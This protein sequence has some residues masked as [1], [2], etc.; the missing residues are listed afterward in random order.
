MKEKYNLFL[1]T[2]HMTA[3]LESVDWDEEK[4]S[5]LINHT[6][7]LFDNS[8]LIDIDIIKSIE[9]KF[10][11]AAKKAIQNIINNELYQMNLHTQGDKNVN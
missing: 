8:K 3:L 11:S 9:K 1:Q 2:H 7:G 5:E 4:L 6:E 10:G